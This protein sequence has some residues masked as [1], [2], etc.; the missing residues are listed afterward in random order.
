MADHTE[1]RRDARESF[2]EDGALV[3]I[4][5]QPAPPPGRNAVAP[6]PITMQA[7]GMQFEYNIRQI[8]T[9]PDSLIKVGDKQLLL[10]ALV[11]DT[12]EL[13]PEPPPECSCIAP[14][15]KKY[16]VKLVKPLA[17]SGEPIIYELN[18]RRG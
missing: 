4:T 8:G 9:Q 11:G 14:D 5:W 6:P 7:W 1:D 10:S 12:D 3:S 16:V 13:L 17:P 15:G 18:I 2:K